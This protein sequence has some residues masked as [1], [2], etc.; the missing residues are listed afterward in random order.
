MK[1]KD[2]YILKTVAGQHIVVPIGS[3]AVKFHGMI[4]L[5]ETGRFLFE[6]L[7]VD[8]ALEALIQKLVDHYDVDLDIATKDVHQFIELLEKHNV[9]V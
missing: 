4:T 5:N 3:E 8:I 6:N 1:V 9:L 7:K 2:N